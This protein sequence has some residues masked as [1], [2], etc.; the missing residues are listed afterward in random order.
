[1]NVPLLNVPI[2]LERYLKT[3]E[4]DILGNRVEHTIPAFCPENA[5]IL[6]LG[7]IPSPKSREFGF[8][9]GHPQNRFWRVLADVL[10]QAVPTGNEAKKAFLRDNYIALWDV[11]ASC[12]IDGAS[13]N[14]IKNPIPNDFSEVLSNGRIKAIYTPGAKATALYKKLCFS[15]NGVPSILLP[16]TSPANCRLKY[17]DLK[18]AYSVILKP[19]EIGE[20]KGQ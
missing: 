15:K 17:E 12:D 9:Y 20:G 13:D 3:I 16:S 11:L 18:E 19:L 5:K 4:G 1:M 2:A 10:N 8:Y 7:T 14:S 6:I